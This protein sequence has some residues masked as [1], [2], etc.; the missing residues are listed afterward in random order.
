MVLMENT[1]KMPYEVA[2][3]TW[4]RSLTCKEFTDETFDA[5]RV[6]RDRWVDKAPELVP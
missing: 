6:F 3:L 5:I 4:T 2:V 1:T